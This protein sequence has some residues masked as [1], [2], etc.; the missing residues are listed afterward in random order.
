M[1]SLTYK[2]VFLG[3]ILFVVLVCSITR[4]MTTAG[5]YQKKLDAFQQQIS[6]KDF[7]RLGTQKNPKTITPLQRYKWF[8]ESKTKITFFYAREAILTQMKTPGM[9][10]V[11]MSKN[12]PDT[13]TVVFVPVMH[14]EYYFEGNILYTYQD[15]KTFGDTIYDIYRSR[16]DYSLVFVARDGVRGIVIT[17]PDPLFRK[18]KKPKYIDLAQTKF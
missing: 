15:R 16:T 5:Y 8:R 2:R 6:D 14:S 7:I 1:I 11:G 4:G 10:S 17:V 3:L 18:A 12:D 9:W 13:E